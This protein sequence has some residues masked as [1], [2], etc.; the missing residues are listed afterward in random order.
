MLKGDPRRNCVQ[1]SLTR[2]QLP[3]PEPYP[4]FTQAHH[5]VTKKVN[6]PACPGSEKRSAEC[7]PTV[8]VREWVF[9]DLELLNVN[10][11]NVIG[12]WMDGFWVTVG[13]GKV[14]VASR[15][16]TGVLRVDRDS[17]EVRTRVQVMGYLGGV[18]RE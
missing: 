11:L 7:L 9:T 15:V 4:C 12:T 2:K 18:R 8:N 5:T 6:P 16:D 17:T 14:Y 3:P 13:V 1:P 10:R